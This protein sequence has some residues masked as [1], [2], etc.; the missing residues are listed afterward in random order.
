MQDYQH[1]F[2]VVDP[3]L[4]SQIALARAVE[5]ATKTGAKITA[6]LCIYDLSYELTTMLSLDERDAMRRAVLA[7][8]EEWLQSLISE[9]VPS[10]VTAHAS[11]VWDKSL[12]ES[13]IRTAIEVKAD[14]V[15]KAASSHDDFAALIFTPTD[16]HILRKCPTPVL[17]VKQHAWPVNGNVLAS[18]NVGTEDEVHA[19]LNQQ[20]VECAKACTNT[21]DATLH[22]VNAF[23]GTIVNLAIEM[24]EFDPHGYNENVKRHH[25]NEMHK[26]ASTNDIPIAQ[27]HVIQGLPEVAVPKQAA[28]LDA[29]LVVIGTVGRA[30]LSAALIGNTAEQV[31]DRLNCDVLAIKPLGFNSPVH[32]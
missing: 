21:L 13:V 14:L 25:Q 10:G 5:L 8:R 23:P 9:Y 6:F 18:I 31:I 3:E 12:Y 19:K 15:L 22:L 28:S 11:V 32:G 24:P 30:G 20:V 17:M 29:E 27:C 16:W 7:D 2:V 4:E 26:F 1:L